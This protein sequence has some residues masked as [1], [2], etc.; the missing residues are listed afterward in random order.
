MKKEVVGVFSVAILVTLYMMP[1]VES[2]TLQPVTPWQDPD[3]PTEG[4][5]DDPSDWINLIYA[6][7]WG[8]VLLGNVL[9]SNPAGIDTIRE[10]IGGLWNLVWNVVFLVSVPLYLLEAFDLVD[11]DE[12]GC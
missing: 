12:D 3:G 8:F 2:Q 5:L 4:G 7:G 10:I 9:T 6:L 1:V 11:S